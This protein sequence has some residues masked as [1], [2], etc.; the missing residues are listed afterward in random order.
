MIPLSVGNLTIKQYHKFIKAVK[1]RS[2]IILAITDL[3]Q[4]DL[5]NMPLKK[6]RNLNDRVGF[7]LSDY[8]DLVSGVGKIRKRKYLIVK[9]KVYKACLDADKLNTNRYT[10][11]KTFNPDENL[12]D[13]CSV[14]YTP[15]K[16]FDKNK[17]SDI[18]KDFEN[19]K[20]KRVLGVV[21][22]YSN[23]SKKQ[24]ADLKSSL[25]QAKL[26][27]MSKLLEAQA[28]QEDLDKVM[29]GITL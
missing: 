17:V 19:I 25:I 2:N 11:L 29:D 14:I 15:L 23:L 28:P 16:G 1:E 3:T 27:L 20:V 4:D 18:S 8:N 26:N 24:K 10:A 13:V 6:L 12:N 22:F 9:G 5:D 7:L 21:F